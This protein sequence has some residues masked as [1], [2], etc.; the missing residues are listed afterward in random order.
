[1]KTV[2]AFALLIGLTIGGFGYLGYQQHLTNLDLQVRVSVLQDQTVALQSQVVNLQ[3]RIDN[4]D[5]SVLAQARASAGQ[6]RSITSLQAG[7]EVI[8]EALLK[9]VDILNALATPET[10]HN[11]LP[12]S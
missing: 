1:M 3:T 4:T 9:I 5:V 6:K 7:Q 2:I 10:R 11:S 8:D 12:R